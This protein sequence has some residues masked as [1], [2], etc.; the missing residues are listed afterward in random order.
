MDA[1]CDGPFYHYQLH[2]DPRDHE[3]GNP[4]QTNPHTPDDNFNPT[5]AW[6]ATLPT[7]WDSAFPSLFQSTHSHGVRQRVL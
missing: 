5:L 2:Y 4:P 1:K 7:Q 6:S 3:G